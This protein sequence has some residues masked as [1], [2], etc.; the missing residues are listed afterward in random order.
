MKTVLLPVLGLPA[1]A[2]VQQVDAGAGPGRT[3]QGIRTLPGTCND[4][5][6]MDPTRFTSITG[7]GAGCVAGRL[8]GTGVRGRRARDGSGCG[9][10]GCA[11][12]EPRASAEPGRGPGTIGGCFLDGGRLRRGEDLYYNLVCFLRPQRDEGS[13]HVIRRGIARRAPTHWPYARSWNETHVEESPPGEARGQQARDAA[14]GANG[15]VRKRNMTF[16]PIPWAIHEPVSPPRRWGHLVRLVA[17]PG[18]GAWGR[19]GGS[20]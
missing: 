16:I 1:R 8:S 10:T 15:G 18:A 7:A 20:Q 4:G 11:C 13:L 5:R 19:T 12:T 14:R 6:R 17:D 9:R 2:T 3:C